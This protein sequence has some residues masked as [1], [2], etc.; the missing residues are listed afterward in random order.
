MNG[1]PFIFFIFTYFNKEGDEKMDYFN[2]IGLYQPNNTNVKGYNKEEKPNI[3]YFLAIDGFSN[4]NM[5]STLYDQFENYVPRKQ[6]Q[7]DIRVAL[8]AYNFALIDLQLYLD[9]NPNDVVTKEL[10]DKYLIAFNDTLQ[11]YEAMYGALTIG[12][13]SNLGSGYSWQKSW[14]FEGGGK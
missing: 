6:N 7:N 4:G 3:N 2:L 9:V 10:F 11:K 5:D 14:P 12:S 8:L 13:T 1:C